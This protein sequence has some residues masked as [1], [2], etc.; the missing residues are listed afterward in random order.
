MNSPVV[1]LVDA[2]Y[3]AGL[4]PARAMDSLMVEVSERRCMMEEPQKSKSVLTRCK[5]YF[6]RK[7]MPNGE[8]QTLMEFGKEYKELTERDKQDLCNEFNKHVGPTHMAPSR[9]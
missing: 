6:G 8:M 4:S 3:R 1:E 2:A 7:M 9:A 5:E